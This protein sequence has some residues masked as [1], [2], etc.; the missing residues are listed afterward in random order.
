MSLASLGLGPQF[1]Q[2]S[3]GPV[4]TAS[5]MKLGEPEKR[6][7]LGAPG[8]TGA[9]L[10]ATG[11]GQRGRPVSGGAGGRRESGRLPV[12]CPRPLPRH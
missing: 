11:R 10:T 1:P 3:S 2:W 5:S 12:R 9:P 7:A 4:Y 8:E 6:V